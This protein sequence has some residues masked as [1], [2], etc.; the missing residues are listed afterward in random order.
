MKTETYRVE[1]TYYENGQKESEIWFQNNKRHRTDN[2]AFQR[3][4]DNGQKWSETWYKNSNCHRID[5]PAFQRWYKNGKKESEEWFKN[6]KEISKNTINIDGKEV[7]EE[8]IMNALK[9]YFK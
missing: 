6:G 1:I 7:S 4:Y 8:T 5:G 3:W 2:P 9:N